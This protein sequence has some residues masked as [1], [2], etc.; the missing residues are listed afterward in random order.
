MKQIIFLILTTIIISACSS[1]SKGIDPIS[2]CACYE[3][4]KITSNKG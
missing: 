3:I 2:P 1:K 4:E